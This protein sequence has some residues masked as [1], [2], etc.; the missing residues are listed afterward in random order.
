M[1]NKL[2][3]AKVMGG[4]GALLALVFPF[5]PYVGPV[6]SI[7]GTVLILIAVKYIADLTKDNTI[8]NN[9]LMSF[10]ISIIALV[11]GI[12]VMAM[13]FIGAG[14]FSFF[15]NLQSANIT[16]FT[17]F[18]EYFQAYFIGCITALIIGWIIMI[19]A[20]IYLR[21]SYNSI[22]EYTKVD[23]FRTTGLIYF[24][25]AITLVVFVGIIILFIA[26]ILEIV[27]FFTLPDQLPSATKG[28]K[29]SEVSS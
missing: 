8:F 20:M 29:E 10:I 28:S 19:I 9:Y 15:E 27:S 18:L 21:R 22:A 24:I 7:A 14:G 11:A 13:T 2:S 1:D 17:S 16:N 4:I 6:L 23:L 12:V 25:G 3:N 26:N 5:I